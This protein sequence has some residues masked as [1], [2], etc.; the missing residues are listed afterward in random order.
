MHIFQGVLN[1]QGGGDPYVPPEP[2]NPDPYWEYVTSYLKFEGAD[3]STSIVDE[4]GLAWTAHGGAAISTTDPIEGSGS[5]DTEKL[6]ATPGYLQCLADDN[7][8]PGAQDFCAEVSV[9]QYG[10]LRAGYFYSRYSRDGA[11]TWALYSSSTTPGSLSALI[12]FDGTNFTQIPANGVASGRMAEAEAEQDGHYALVRDGD[13]FSFYLNGVRYGSYTSPTAGAPLFDGGAPALINASVFSGAVSTEDR[14]FYDNAKFTLGVPRY[15]GDYVYPWRDS[16]PTADRSQI[17]IALVSTDVNHASHTN[18]KTALTR[19]GFSA[20]N[21]LSV[22]DT[23]TSLPACDIVVICRGVEDQTEFDTLIAPAWDSGTPVVF[24]GV[25]A[26]WV[27]NQAFP[28][29]GSFANLTGPLYVLGATENGIGRSLNTS[30]GITQHIRPEVPYYWYA[31]DNSYEAGLNNENEFV[32]EKLHQWDAGGLEYRTD[33][34]AVEA[35][36]QRLNAAGPSPARAV[37]AMQCYG[38]QA[39]YMP[40]AY[41]VLARSIE[42]CLGYE[43]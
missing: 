31:S 12:S 39:D 32:G 25:G 28:H 23:A 1:S 33:L 11:R 36:T 5:L 41:E 3:G 26:G 6:S 17:V 40:R 2:S 20:A 18:T 19:A 15:V 13:M 30:H 29:G 24:G 4:K 10:V 9:R 22:L 8:N 16:G 42:W 37:V 34:I 38:G 21:I 27:S 35:G 14:T 7:F 43:Y